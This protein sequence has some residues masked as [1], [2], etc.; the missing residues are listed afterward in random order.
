[1]AQ[2]VGTAR[3]AS[4]TAAPAAA[5]PELTPR[6]QA[7]TNRTIARLQHPAA[8]HTTPGDVSEANCGCPVSSH[9]LQPAVHTLEVHAAVT[10]SQKP[11]FLGSPAGS[12][13]SA[14]QHPHPHSTRTA[15]HA[16]LPCS[17]GQHVAG[18][19]SDTQGVPAGS[20]PGRKVTQGPLSLMARRVIRLL[21]LPDTQPLAAQTSHTSLAYRCPCFSQCTDGAILSRTPC[22][23]GQPGGRQQPAGCS[24]SHFGIV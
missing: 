7:R 2:A 15:K 8:T 10:G 21:L 4:V 12:P 17:S 11:F 24:T 16:P 22:V 20:L 9:G 13:T 6:I 5:V 1:V 19:L 14:E 18:M 23:P 3:R